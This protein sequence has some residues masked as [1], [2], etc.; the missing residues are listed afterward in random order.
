VQP[1]A[2]ADAEGNVLVVTE[3]TSPKMLEKLLRAGT[4]A[5]GC[6]AMMTTAPMSGDFVHRFG[7]PH[8]T[9]QAW[10]LGDAVLSARAVKADP[11]EAILKESGGARLMGGKV[12]DIARRVMAGFTRG[13]LTVAGL[14]ADAGRILTVDIQNEYLIAREDEKII[15]M[16]P[17]LICIVD[18]ETGRAIGTEELRYG[19]RIDV[20]SMP[21]PVLLR[22]EIALETVGPR[23]FGY[24]FDFVP[25]GVS[26]DA[27]AVPHYKEDA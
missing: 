27:P 13:K 10:S 15:T 22:S 7:V 11:V 4:I 14:D 1:A 23:A 3:A 2:L 24:D 20:L 18:S 17:D 21:A 8:T 5:M 19:L 9:S 6:T 26:A 16:V 12:T 25:I